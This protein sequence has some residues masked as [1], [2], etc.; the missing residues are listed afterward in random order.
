MV[1]RQSSGV[2]SSSFTATNA[3]FSSEAACTH[4][5]VIE[6][7]EPIRRFVCLIIYVETQS[8]GG[9]AHA[10]HQAQ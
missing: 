9:E 3:V 6:F 2:R 10:A 7:Y 4:W 8:Y 1:G 5:F